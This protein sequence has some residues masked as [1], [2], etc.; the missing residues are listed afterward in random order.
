MSRPQRFSGYENINWERH[1]FNTSKP[2]YRVL[3]SSAAKATCGKKQLCKAFG[4]SRG[5]C[6][7]F[8]ES[9]RVMPLKCQLEPRTENETDLGSVWSRRDVGLVGLQS[10]PLLSAAG[11]APGYISR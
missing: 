4:G 5:S 3:G 10:R 1:R 8:D 2:V 9:P 7:K 11:E 6:T